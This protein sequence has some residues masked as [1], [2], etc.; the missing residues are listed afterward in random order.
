[1]A[2]YFREQQWTVEQATDRPL[3]RMPFDHKGEPWT[4]YAEAREAQ[5]RVIFYAVPPVTVPEPKRAAMAELI[6]RANYGVTIGNLELDMSDGEVRCKTSLDVTGDRL[7]HP[8]LHSLVLAN[9]KVM[10]HYLPAI[11]AVLAGATPADAI[12]RAGG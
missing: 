2:A 12:A 7:S 9:L 6:A 5:H 1:M 11:R 8:L 10:H 4:C 3:L